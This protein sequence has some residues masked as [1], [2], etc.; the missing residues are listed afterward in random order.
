[1]RQ[2]G[3]IEIDETKIINVPAGIPGFQD[4]KRYSMLQK[5]EAAPFLFF[6]SVDD[7]D[8]SFVILDP[9]SVIQDYS[10][11][12]K[13]LNRVVSWD[14]ANDEIT[15]FVIV[16][17]PNGDPESATAN[18]LAPLVI[19]TKKKEGLQLILQNTTYSCQ[20]PLVN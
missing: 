9:K 1:T 20:H 14:F 10:V 4:K 7:P 19:N 6:Q 11:K 16:T 2:F 18:F 17:I 12:E 3:E 15:C 5:E 13:D 8:L